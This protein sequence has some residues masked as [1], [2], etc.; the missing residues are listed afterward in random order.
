MK[1]LL[2]IV[3]LLLLTA[4]T[5]AQ[6]DVTKFLGIPVDGTKPVMI[7]K[8]KTKGFTYN[9][10][11][12]YLEGE[13][14]GWDVTVSVVTNNNMVYRICLYDKTWLNEADIRIRFNNLCRQFNKNQKYQHT[15]SDF[16]I[17]DD[18]D[19]S[20]EM[21]V[22]NKRYE[23]SFY[24]KDVELDSLAE[25]RE[26]KSV[27]LSK[28]TE[29]QIANPTDEQMKDMEK[30]WLSHLIFGTMYKKSV[31]FMITERFGRYRILMFYDNKY[32]EP[33][34]EDL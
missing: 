12:G 25:E 13:F 6:Q 5:W 30:M 21:S 32:N 23:A 1:N 19:I 17:P 27:W 9:S 34:G 2:T 33:D 31:W 7:Q 28:Y 24:Q 29:E 26:R 11:Y 14:N 22:N 20:Y 8:L 3:S 10:T 16:T 15:F 4:A 18:E